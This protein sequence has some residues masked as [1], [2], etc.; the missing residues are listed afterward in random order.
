MEDTQTAKHAHPA[1][2]IEDWDIV[3]EASLESFPAS[4]PPAHGTHRT[5]TAS[6]APRVEPAPAPRRPRGVTGKARSIAVAVVALGSLV[7]WL[8][9]LRRHHAIAT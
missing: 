1:S 2:H 6:P 8:R 7:L 9:R 3:D 5:Q 4:D